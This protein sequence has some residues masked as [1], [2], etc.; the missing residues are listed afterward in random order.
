MSSVLRSGC[1][2]LVCA[3][4]PLHVRGPHVK[5]GAVWTDYDS[6][7]L[8]SMLRHT[9]DRSIQGSHDRL[10]TK[11]PVLPTAW[12][13]RKHMHTTRL[14]D[15]VE[16]SV[17]CWPAQGTMHDDIASCDCRLHVRSC[18]KSSVVPTP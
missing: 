15:A 9:Q 2:S 5:Q 10:L 17:C 4:G 16:R 7:R 3:L 13:A 11:A 14:I 6:S 1:Y 18:G 8:S 12:R